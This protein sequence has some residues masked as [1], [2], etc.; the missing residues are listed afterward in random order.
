M[1]GRAKSYTARKAQRERLDARKRY[2]AERGMCRNHSTR[3]AYNGTKSCFRCLEKRRDA[4][5]RKK[6][7]VFEKYGGSICNCCGETEFDF[8]QLDHVENNGASHKR[9]LSSNGTKSDG[10]TKLYSWVIENGYPEGF[11]VL[12]AN[13]NWGKRISGI[14]PHKQK[15]GKFY[16]PLP[17]FNGKIIDFN[18]VEKKK[19]QIEM[20]AF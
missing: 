16:A 13:C 5:I 2:W 6:K 15:D 19:D 12:C 8:L 7:Q 17:Y 3:P 11:Q 14:C 9:K 10:S 1:G 4:N 18:A 20:F